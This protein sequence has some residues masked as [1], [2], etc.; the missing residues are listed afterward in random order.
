MTSPLYWI[1]MYFII[2]YSLVPGIIPIP[3]FITALVLGTL[4]TVIM[5][6]SLFMMPCIN[7]AKAVKS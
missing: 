4:I 1:V 5:I 2:R 6:G 3:I 7:K